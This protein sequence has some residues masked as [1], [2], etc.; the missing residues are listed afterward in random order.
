[1]RNRIRRF[2]APP[3]F[4]DEEKTQTARILNIFGWSAIAVLLLL[5]AARLPSWEAMRL[6]TKLILPLLILI[7]LGAQALL[8]LGYVRGAAV[9]AVALIWL[10][11][12]WQASQADG[13]RD[14][15]LISHLAIVLLA[16]LLLG[17]REG[18]FVGTMSVAAIWYFAF[19]ESQEIQRY[20][21]DSPFNFARDLTAVFVISIVLIYLLVR[22]LNLSLLGARQELRERLRSDER[23]QAQTRYLTAL[24]QT[25]FDL[26]NRLEIDPLLESILARLSE[27]LDTPHV[28][29]DLLTEDES[30]LKQAMGKG[31]FSGHNG[32]LTRKGV[33]LTGKVWEQEKTLLVENYNQWEGRNPEAESVGFCS[34]LG[35]PLKSGA[36][37]VG[38]LIAAHMD[39]QSKF[40][41][42][43]VQLLERFAALASLAIDNARLHEQ[44]QTELRERREI[45]QDLR[46]SE[47]R[48][49]KV[50][51]NNNIAIAIVTLEEGIFLEANEA[52]WRL[53]GLTPQKALGHSVL[54]FNLWKHPDERAR[55]VEELLSK[56][57]L[58]NVEVEFPAQ[59]TSIGY[60]ELIQIKEQRCI[61]C[62]FYDVTEQKRAQDALRN[63]EARTRAILTA[64]P[65]MIFEIS[66][67]GIFLD[68]I[69]SS[70][71]SPL[72]PPAQFLGRNMEELLPPEITAQAKFALERAIVSGQIQTLEYSLPSADE[73][74]H[75][76]A[77]ICAV[78][79]ASAVV[80]VRDIT[81]RKWVETEREKLI[82]ELEVKN[83]ELER[84]AYTASHDL[85]SPLITIKGFLGFLEKDAA[86]GNINRLRSDL[87][88]ISDATDKMQTLLNDLL[89]LSRVGRLAAAPQSVPFEEIVREAVE[90]VQGR[91]QAH[92]VRVR[93]QKNLP[94][95]FGERQ[96]LVEVLQN[97]IDNAAKFSRHIP[98]PLVEVG[99][100]GYEND[101]PIFF[102]RDRGIGI[103]P[104]HHE[105]IFGL[106]NKLDMDSEGS[107]VG[108]ALVKRI[109]EVH[110]GRIWVQSEAGSGST[111][112]F[113]L[114]TKSDS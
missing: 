91:L 22:N 113:T 106:F 114:P 15:A 107:G 110:G 48:F 108:L 26:L 80:M 14:V 55:F 2:L 84:F 104:A 3:I 90:M 59:K 63:A 47:E 61:L 77:R 1:M 49:R 87:Q 50:F 41:R 105:R 74:R 88:R 62:M 112:F 100:A 25:A 103:D 93:I 33:G 16:A 45:E 71:M 13:I 17:W 101:M 6:S 35:T 23:L 65:D 31:I 99:Q 102:V 97:L 79:P 12:A 76:E 68:Y 10:T 58:Q 44:A 7:L 75:F 24:H 40:T 89:E 111:F 52:F 21:L 18:L 72:L 19:Q 69:P 86:S 70:E 5:I 81:Q 38:T 66:R 73:V 8:R 4:E 51:N 56:G 20:G 29:I 27:L 11:T 54:E 82:Q 39:A 42:E 96:R 67:D 57:S 92:G 60:Y 43:Q 64:I 28:G 83:A 9:F 36:K 109:V 94:V 98:K 32:A 95:V 30:M 34:V 37:V 78:T 46:S 85:K 53:S